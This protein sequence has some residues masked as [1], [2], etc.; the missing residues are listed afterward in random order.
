MKKNEVNTEEWP[1]IYTQSGKKLYFN[2]WIKVRK[3]TKRYKMDFSH[4]NNSTNS[5]K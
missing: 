3:G 1:P 2:F 4:E 5:P